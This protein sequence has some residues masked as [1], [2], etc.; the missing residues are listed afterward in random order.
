MGLAERHLELD[1]PAPASITTRRS[2]CAT[3]RT[4][5]LGT[6]RDRLDVGAQMGRRAAAHRPAR[7]RSSPASCPRSAR[8]WPRRSSSIVPSSS[9]WT[10][11]T[12]TITP[13]SGSAIAVSSA[14][15]PL[16]RIAISSTST[17]V[18]AGAPRISSGSP[19]SVLKFARE[20]TVA[21]VAGEQREQQVLGRGL[22]GRAGDAD[23]ARRPS[24]RRQAVASACSAAS[25]SAAAS[26]APGPSRA[27]ARACSG[28]ASAPQ[29]PRRARRRRSCRRR[30]P[31]RAARRTGRR[32]RRRASR[33]WRAAA[34]RAGRARRSGLRRPPQ[35]PVG[36]SSASSGRSRRRRR[37]RGRARPRI[38]RA[39]VTSSNGSL[40]P[41]S[42]SWPCSW[43]LPAIT[44]TSPRPAAAIARA[45][46]AADRPRAR[47]RDRCR[48]GSRAR[49]PR[50]PRSGGYP[51]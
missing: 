39:T 31:A 18:P 44:T 26:S 22:T 49:S 17:S 46:A 27:A 30:V 14:I 36:L 34:H 48:P 4:S 35:R 25:G 6:E 15:W 23:H 19:I 11:P 47:P 10:G 24:S 13:T 45:I 21:V 32:G 33:S 50:D 2:S 1:P 40:R 37:R 28:V 9:R 3:S 29:A 5:P 42:N 20:A 41:F 51:R 7:S 8:P 16:P 43:P 38:S 12:L